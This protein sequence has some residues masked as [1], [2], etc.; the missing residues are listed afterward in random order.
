M[1]LQE[2]FLYLRDYFQKKKTVTNKEMIEKKERRE[3]ARRQKKENKNK[4][5]KS[6]NDLIPARL[7]SKSNKFSKTKAKAHWQQI[8]ELR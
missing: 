2:H 3:V 6:Q 1:K 5:K 4:R 7:S 8:W